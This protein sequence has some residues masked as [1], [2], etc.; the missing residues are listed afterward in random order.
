MKRKA[1]H[2]KLWLP[3]GFRFTTGSVPTPAYG[4]GAIRKCPEGEENKQNIKNAW[5][6]L[7]FVPSTAPGNDEEFQTED[8]ASED[9]CP[10]AKKIKQEKVDNRQWTQQH[11]DAVQLENNLTPPHQDNF[12][13]ADT[14]N[15][16]GPGGFTPLMLTANT[17]H[18][19]QNA[20]IIID[21]LLKKGAD[22]NLQTDHN[23]ETALHLAAINGRAD[24]VEKL[25][26]VQADPN[27]IDHIGRTSL[28]R[29]ISADSPAVYKI[30]IRDPRTD[31]NAKKTDG[32]T[33]LMLACNLALN[34]AVA[35]LL[36]AD[37]DVNITDNEGKTA[38]HWAALV[39]NVFAVQ[40]LLQKSCNI[41][42]QTGKDETALLLAAKEGNF[43]V[44]E[45]LLSWGANR[46]ITD[47]QDRLARDIAS[48]RQFNNIVELLDQT[49]T[50]LR[51]G[52][53][54]NI[55]QATSKPRKKRS[56]K[57]ADRDKKPRKTKK[58]K[59]AEKLQQ[60]RLTPPYPQ[61][62]V[63]KA[64]ELPP[65]S[66]A[67]MQQQQI[68]T[69]FAL[70]CVPSTTWPTTLTPETD[71]NLASP[72]SNGSVCKNGSPS[73]FQGV[74]MPQPQYNSY[75]PTPP[76]QTSSNLMPLTPTPTPTTPSSP[77]QWDSCSP[78]SDANWSDDTHSPLQMQQKP[79]S[80]KYYL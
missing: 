36:G 46:D 65:C 1:A 73:R 61:A 70:D 79:R 9:E 5:K 30:L 63:L 7:E 45:I 28:H 26:S 44:V 22:I 38:L 33:A 19:V 20:S 58:Q 53:Q 6:A 52:V 12:S 71:N 24:V 77:G 68:P 4:P 47:Y 49:T 37:S 34:D 57:E 78:N 14:V 60:T 69:D 8:F 32:R 25:L 23:G 43:Q 41:D 64:E 39:D 76:S 17:Q 66:N 3:E 27:I 2:G 50:D 59:E 74:Q 56:S 75:Y 62:P 16:K 21:D 35:T 42:A 31:L 51:L 54:Q 13:D 48:E 72:S 80:N 11:Y 18:A 55:C 15:A 29:A 10:K 40:S 67:F